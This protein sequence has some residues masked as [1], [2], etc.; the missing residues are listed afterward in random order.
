MLQLNS[1]SVT[2]N[3]KVQAVRNV[4]FQA[5]QGEFIGIIGPSGSGKSSLLKAINLLVQPCSGQILL[6]GRHVTGAGGRDLRRLRRDIGFVFQNYNLIE[7]LT[8]IENVLLGKLGAK[9]SWE[10]LIGN[11]KEE[12]YA[13]ALKAL[14]HVGLSDKA[15]ERASHLSGGQKQRVAIAKALCQRP[16]IILADEPVSSLDLATSAVVMEYFERVNRKKNMTILV[17]LHDVTLAK[18]YCRRILALKEGQLIF[19]G[20]TEALSDEKLNEIYH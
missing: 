19:D 11:F 1:V 14:S 4:S 18:K 5:A 6:D 15:F 9:S 17:N 12:E 2:Y 20:A 10:S 7:R 16:H 3:E 13:H 8:V